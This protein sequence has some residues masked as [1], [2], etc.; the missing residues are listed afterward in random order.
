MVPSQVSI[1]GYIIEMRV[2]R[3]TNTLIPIIVCWIANPFSAFFMIQYMKKAVPNEII[4]SA[5]IDGYPEPYIYFRIVLPL[6]KPGIATVCTLIFL[7]SWNSYMLPLIAI[8]NP[9]WYTIPLFIKSI[10]ADYLDDYG[11]RMA[12]L[13]LAIFPVLILFAACSRTFIKG[14][15]EGAVKG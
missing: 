1:V 8:S 14:I 5:R 9:K 12:A 2:L 4:E 15:T 3:W 7:W 6:I 10:G 11:A 13:S